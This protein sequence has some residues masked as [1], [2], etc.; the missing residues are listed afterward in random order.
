MY[1]YKV[2]FQHDET[3]KTKTY[4]VKAEGIIPAIE[5]A[6]WIAPFD[7]KSLLGWTITKAESKD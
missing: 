3:R 1:T 2:T 7:K 6:G 5:K 4:T